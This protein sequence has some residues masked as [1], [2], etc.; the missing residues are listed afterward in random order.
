ML[1]PDYNSKE[2][3]SLGFILRQG[4]E[5]LEEIMRTHLNITPLAG[6]LSMEEQETVKET[7]A[8][9]KILHGTDAP[10]GA[11]NLPIPE[12]LLMQYDKLVKELEATGTIADYVA[13]A[14]DFENPL[15]D[16]VEKQV[17]GLSFNTYK[18]LDDDEQ[19]MVDLVLEKLEDRIIKLQPGGT[20]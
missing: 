2:E 19:D 4:G 20:R 10:T 6:G 13:G 7:Q 8:V 11:D 15:I 5:D 3:D 14:L 12:I 17:T 9:Y 1:R 16:Y 18:D